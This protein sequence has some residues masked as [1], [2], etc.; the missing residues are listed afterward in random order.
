MRDHHILQ[1]SPPQLTSKGRTDDVDAI[2]DIIDDAHRTVDVAVMD[3]F[4]RMLYTKNQQSVHNNVW[5]CSLNCLITS[6][7]LVTPVS[8]FAYAG[9]QS[10][11]AVVS[12]EYK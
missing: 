1:S 6:A 5:H 9:I 2:V 7:N 11:E 4:P 3:Y 12:H 8:L 10:F